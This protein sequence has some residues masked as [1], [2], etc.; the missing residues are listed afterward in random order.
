MSFCSRNVS[1]LKGI[2][3]NRTSVHHGSHNYVQYRLK[4]EPSVPP[5][6]LR[7]HARPPHCGVSVREGS[8]LLH[9]GQRFYS[10]S[11]GESVTVIT[12]VPIVIRDK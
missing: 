1:D 3:W 12:V 9:F 5:R 6:M 7:Q 10:K 2:L 4:G 8:P 11:R